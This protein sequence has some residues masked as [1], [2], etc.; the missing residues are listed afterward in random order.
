ML[1]GMTSTRSDGA[2]AW[3]TANWPAPQLRGIAKNRHARHAR[4]DLLKQLQ[5]FPA[6]LNSKMHE[7]GDI[8][9]RPRQTVDEA[10]AD[11]IGD[12]RE[13][14]RHGAGRLLN[15]PTAAV[16]LAR[17]TSGASAAN[18]AACLRMSRHWWPNDIDVER[19]DQR[20][21]LKRQALQERRNA[22][23]KIRIV[24]CRGQEYANTSQRSDCCPRAASG[25]P[26]RHQEA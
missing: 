24:R 14:D 11:R 6:M 2:T 13:H 10:R 7:T 26:P 4:R 17:M 8:A 23:L 16:P 9:A 25:Q 3:I 21:S 5:P 1:T 15:G 12:G 22:G 18:S 19:C 20:S